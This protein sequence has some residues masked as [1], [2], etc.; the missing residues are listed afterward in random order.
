M[1]DGDQESVAILTIYD[2]FN[3]IAMAIIA[4]VTL[5]RL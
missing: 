3:L 1:A 5:R 2:F 4:Y